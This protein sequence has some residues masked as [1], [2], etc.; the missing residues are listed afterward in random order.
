M[1]IT[2]G[3][4]LGPYE[5]LSPIGAGGMGEV[6]R[7]RHVKLRREVAIKVLPPEFA[8]DSGRLARFEREARTASALNHPNIVTIHDVAE[9]DGTTYIAMELV[10]GRTLRDIIADGP[11]PID[12]IV[13]LA[14]QIA[15]GLAKAHAAGIVHRD[16]KPANVM[17]NGDEL[18]KILDFGLAK[19]LTTP[20]G[21]EPAGPLTTE[22]RPGVIIGTPHYMSPEQLSGDH[23]DHRSDQFSLG[24]VLYEMVGGKLPFDGP[25][26]RAIISAILVNP[27]PPLKQLRSDAPP[28][29]EQI[30]RRCLEKDPERRFQSTADVATALR[31][32]GER[33]AHTMRSPIALVRKRT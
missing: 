15:D 29:L 20:E 8:G 11:M 25:S 23:V 5:I 9:Q 19:P 28:D 7:A 6:H 27:P 30:I 1:A 4:R 31:L 16:I 10:D 18:V 24:V 13:R 3:A 26:V 17:V 22:T 21:Q 33:R 14:S 32:H 2:A 12:R